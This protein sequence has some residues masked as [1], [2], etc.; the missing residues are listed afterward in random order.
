M[1]HRN[2]KRSDGQETGPAGRLREASQ[3]KRY[4]NEILKAL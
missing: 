4:L 1:K 3:R 2:K